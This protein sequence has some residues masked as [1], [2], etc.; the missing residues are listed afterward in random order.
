M[1]IDYKKIYRMAERYAQRHGRSEDSQDF[2]Q[3]CCIYGFEHETNEIFIA[4]RFSDFIRKNYGDKRTTSGAARQKGMLSSSRFIESDAGY[5][6]SDGRSPGEATRYFA[7]LS[8]YERLI[9]VLHHKYEL[10]YS[11]AADC[12]GVSESRICQILQG[13]QE[14]INRTIAGKEREI[15]RARAATL[16]KILQEERQKVECGTSQK[17][18]QKE[19]FAMEGF[20]ETGL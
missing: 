1:E 19:S 4:R 16:E 14:K 2:A 20:D 12:Q 6:S 13:I 17:M 15:S 3:E 18:A 11:T 8:R 5:E 9:Y 10:P 7:Y